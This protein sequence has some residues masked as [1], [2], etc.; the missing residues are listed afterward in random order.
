MI[1]AVSRWNLLAFKKGSEVLVFAQGDTAL[2]WYPCLLS[3][4]ANAY[5]FGT[6]GWISGWFAHEEGAEQGYLEPPTLHCLTQMPYPQDFGSANNISTPLKKKN[7]TKGISVQYLK[8]T[9]VLSCSLKDRNFIPKKEWEN[10]SESRKVWLST[11]CLEQ[12]PKQAGESTEMQEKTLLL[13]KIRKLSFINIH[14][15]NWPWDALSLCR[16][17]T[18]QTSFERMAHGLAQCRGPGNGHPIFLYCWSIAGHYCEF[19]VLVNR[20]WKC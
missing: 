5:A 19:Q 2:C 1:I 7:C 17:A 14:S 20:M 3:H 12:S 11:H 13:N 10:L 16:P 6:K 4:S 9:S 8:I 18:C 15:T